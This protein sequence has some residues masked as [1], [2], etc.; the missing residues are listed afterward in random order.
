MLVSDMLA[1]ADTMSDLGVEIGPD[2][3]A[4]E[5]DYLCAREWARTVDDILWRRTKL[6]LWFDETAR[7]NLNDY[8]RARPVQDT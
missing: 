5:V 6:G 3:Y 4:R 1:G 8:L 2:L 7:A